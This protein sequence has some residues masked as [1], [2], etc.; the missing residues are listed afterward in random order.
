MQPPFPFGW[1]R[2]PERLFRLKIVIASLVDD[3]T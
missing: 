1:T 2:A 3:A